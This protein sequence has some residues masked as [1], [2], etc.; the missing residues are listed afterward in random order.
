MYAAIVVVSSRW[1]TQPASDGSFEWPDVPPGKYR[2]LAWQRFGGLYRRE[3]IVQT[4]R[5]QV[6]MMIP[7][8]DLDKP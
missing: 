1:A 7:E 2:L 6:T 5:I 3:L 4:N 8:E